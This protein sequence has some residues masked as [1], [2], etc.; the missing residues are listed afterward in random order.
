MRRRRPQEDASGKPSLGSVVRGRKAKPAPEAEATPAPTEEPPGPDPAVAPPVAD[1]AGPPGQQEVEAAWAAGVLA[2]LPVKIRSKW[3]GGRWVEPGGGA[4]RF[5]VPNE[6]HQKACDESRRDVEQALAAH[7]G[8]AVAVAVVVEGGA[9]PPAGAGV[10]GPPAAP[11][12]RGRRRRAR[13][14]RPPRVARR[15]SDAPTNGVD[16]LLREFGG[17]E[18]VE[19]EQ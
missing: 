1:A 11:R 12:P 10:P 9:D 2:G 19:E 8:S 5:A 3:R 15:R 18:L 14:H 7:F 6:W 16:L 13:P 4:V 17:G